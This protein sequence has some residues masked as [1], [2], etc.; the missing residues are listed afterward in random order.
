MNKEGCEQAKLTEKG[1]KRLFS[2]EVA[3]GWQQPQKVASSTTCKHPPPPPP[4]PTPPPP[5]PAH[6]KFFRLIGGKGSNTYLA[7][8]TAVKA[9]QTCGTHQQNFLE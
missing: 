1:N 2:E 8:K 3:A 7:W 9:S 6:S 4:P 5:P